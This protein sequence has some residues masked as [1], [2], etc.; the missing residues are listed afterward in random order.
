[1]STA[2][3]ASTVTTMPAHFRTVPVLVDPHGKQL[4]AYQIEIASDPAR[5]TLV[6]VEGG[7]HPAFNAAPYYDPT[8]LNHNRVIVAAFS[9]S[10][11]LPS[12]KTRVAT[13][14]VR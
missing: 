11:D 9:T 7:E 10:S 13:L 2:Q 6:G 8:A 5:V 14:H 4:G 3:T 12:T 1:A